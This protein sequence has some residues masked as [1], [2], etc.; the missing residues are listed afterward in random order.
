LKTL[1]FNSK[2]TKISPPAVF[3]LKITA[4]AP[5]KKIFLLTLYEDFHNIKKDFHNMKED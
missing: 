2:F 4:L 3:L 1:N 5:Y